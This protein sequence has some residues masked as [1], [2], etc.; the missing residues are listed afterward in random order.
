MVCAMI[1][2][3][4]ASVALLWNVWLYDSLILKFHYRSQRRVVESQ[5]R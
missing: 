3:K 5:V 4:G 2:Q 1:A